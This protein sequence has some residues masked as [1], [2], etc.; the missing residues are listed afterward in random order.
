M[1][2]T[3]SKA[4]MRDFAYLANFYGWEASTVEEVKEETRGNPELMRY[5]QRLARAHRQGYR[6]TRENNWQRLEAWE[7]LQL[8]GDIA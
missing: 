1:K 8:S 7:Q 3:V 4:F 2:V 5:W 6:Q